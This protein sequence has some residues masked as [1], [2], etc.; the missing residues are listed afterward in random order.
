MPGHNLLF[1]MKFKDGR[2]RSGVAMT[3]TIDDVSLIINRLSGSV[4]AYPIG[5][6]ADINIKTM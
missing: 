3:V 5:D 2:R 4:E 6:V 1:N